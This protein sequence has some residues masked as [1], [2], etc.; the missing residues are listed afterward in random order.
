MFSN[1]VNRRASAPSAMASSPIVA[2]QMRSSTERPSKRRRTNEI[3]PEEDFEQTQ[4][5]IHLS[6]LYVIVH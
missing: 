5:R 3:D 1:N 6:S 2:S 4:V